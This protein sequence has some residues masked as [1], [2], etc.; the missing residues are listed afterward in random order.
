MT[1]RCNIL[2]RVLNAVT[3]IRFGRRLTI[4][5]SL[6]NL[7]PLDV[8]ERATMG[9][10]ALG[11]TVCALAGWLGARDLRAA[12]VRKAFLVWHPL[13]CAPYLPCLLLT[14]DLARL[15]PGRRRAG[16]TDR[17]EFCLV[18]ADN[19]C[20][21][22]G[23]YACL[24]PTAPRT[25]LPAAA[26]PS[27]RTAIP[28]CGTYRRARAAAATRTTRTL[29]APRAL[30]AA[31]YLRYA[32]RETPW[33]TRLPTLAFSAAGRWGDVS[34]WWGGAAT[35]C[36]A[37]PA[38]RQNTVLRRCYA[39]RIAAALRVQRNVWP[40]CR[41]TFSCVDGVPCAGVPRLYSF[42][43][44]GCNLHASSLFPSAR[45]HICSAEFPHAGYKNAGR[46]ACGM[47]NVSC[48]SL[49]G[50]GW[51]SGMEQQRASSYCP[52]PQSAVRVRATRIRGLLLA[53]HRTGSA[54]G[55]RR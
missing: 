5:P 10:F 33:Q 14:S 32:W 16:R 40:R 18:P 9:W 1:R 47:A 15:H 27:A 17:R 41:H 24:L 31:H 44:Q 12:C 28:R 19:I 37:A 2:P 30:R 50:S 23:S 38:G 4:L 48:H 49:A 34:C 39:G 25:R 43:R 46:R 13:L 29:H 20:L 55:S 53:F 22:A 26:L 8:F 54:P 35:C 45:R 36:A 52:D 21:A 11:C 6:L 42:W 7:T 3:A 51:L